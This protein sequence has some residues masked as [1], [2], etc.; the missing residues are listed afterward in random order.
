M[1]RRQFIKQ[2]TL[3]SIGGILLPSTFLS[4][5]RKETL[6][7]DVDYGGKVLIIGA[8]AAGLYA[9]FILKAMGIDFTI[10]EATEKIGG[11]MGKLTGFSDYTIDTGA[12]WLH[13]Q[14]NILGD[15]IKAKKIKTTADD[16]TLSYWFKNQIVGTLPQDPFIFEG[17]N[18]PDISF[19]EYGH[20]KGLGSDFDYIVEAI[21]GDQGASASL[22]SAYWNSKDEENWVSGDEDFKFEK[23]YFDAIE[24]HIAN[25]ILNNIIF[26]S[27]VQSINYAADKIIIQDVN[28]NTHLADKVIITVPISILKLNELNFTPAL[29]AEKIDAFSKFGMGAGMKVFLKFTTKFYKDVLYGGAVCGAYVDDTLGKTT[30]DNV[31]L[32]FVM[33]DQASNLHALGNDE[34]IT[35]ALLQEL[36]T[37]YN[38]Q[39]STAYISSIVFDYTAKPYIKGAYGYSTLGMGNARQI[40]AETIDKKLYFAGEAMNTNGHHQTVHGAVESGYNAVLNLLN[41]VKK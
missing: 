1:D 18:L 16:S 14:N 8:G 13:G 39:A 17:E 35:N 38:G 20:Q 27:P 32:A 4:A 33:G 31:L 3:F 41:D 22:I 23:S 24:E 5:C 2:S 28:N 11:R 29:P 21:A 10:L 26:N 19:K 9:G 37:M 30:S 25:P 6:F 15:L 36:D 34:A 40:A 12:Q 7:E